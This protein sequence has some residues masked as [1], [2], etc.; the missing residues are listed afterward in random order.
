MADYKM[1]ID[2]EYEAIEKTL[3]SFPKKPLSQLSELEL[4]G[5][6]A[7]THNFY[8]GVENI[9]KQIFQA[10]SLK[11]PTDA[12]WHQDLLLTSV[13]EKII[14]ERLADELKEFL[15]FRHF[16]AHAYALDLQPQRMEPLVEKIEKVFKNFRNEINKIAV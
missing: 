16:F 11:I 5:I 13:R 7:L 4:A 14:S 1:R 3:A 12:S 15:A 2:A 9:L 6:A 8:N 10:K